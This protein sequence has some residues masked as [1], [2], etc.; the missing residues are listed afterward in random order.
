MK[1]NPRDL[2]DYID[3]VVY[4]EKI[5][6]KPHEKGKGSNKAH[7]KNERGDFDRKKRDSSR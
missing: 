2:D 4:R 5:K 6:H 3:K 7:N 1:I